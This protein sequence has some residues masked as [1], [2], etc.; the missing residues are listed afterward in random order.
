LSLNFSAMS[1]EQIVSF[2][3]VI[4]DNMGGCLSFD[5]VPVDDVAWIPTYPYYEVTDAVV[6]AIGASWRTGYSTPRKLSYSEKAEKTDAGEYY[7]TEITGFYPKLSPSMLSVMNS[8]MGRHFL[9]KIKDNNGYT[10]LVGTLEEPLEFTFDQ[11]PGKN[12]REANGFNFRFYGAHMHVS[13][14]YNPS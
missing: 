1:T 13:P 11:Q 12:A 8:M 2:L 14:F 6:L 9:L 7:I 4:P 5:F 3:D 10:R